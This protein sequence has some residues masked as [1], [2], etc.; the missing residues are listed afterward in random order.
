M[1]LIFRGPALN[2]QGGIP[3]WF[4]S[5]AGPA[6]TWRQRGWVG[7]VA[8]IGTLLRAE[9]P[10]ACADHG[11]TIAYSVARDGP[12]TIVV[13]SPL[14]TSSWPGRSRPWSIS[15]AGSRLAPG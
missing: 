6:A 13:V 8:T 5:C 15:G 9:A 12:V 10:Y 3:R 11:V 2:S 1:I 14:I 7:R 4:S